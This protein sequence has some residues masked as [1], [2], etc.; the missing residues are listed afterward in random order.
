MSNLALFS[1]L[2]FIVITIAVSFW[3]KLGLEKDLAV[4][5]A[6]SA[7]QLFLIGY[8]LQYIFRAEQP[9]LILLMVMMMVSVASWN[10]AQRGKGLKGI[11]WR[12]AITIAFT[13][14]VTISLLLGFKIIEPASQSIIP[15]C[16]MVAGNSMIASSLFLAQM[17]RE[18]EASR[19]EIETLLSLG[20][21]NRQSIQDVIARAVK[22]SMIPNIDNMK[23]VGLVM[24][25]GVMTGM[26]VAGANPLEAVRY[27]ILIMFLFATSPAITSMLLS[28]LTYQLWFTK[29][30]MLKEK[31]EL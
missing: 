18:V 3:Q 11:W 21:T 1:T 17:K 13:E 24:L 16:G 30:S 9:F 29:N 5:T 14:L 12:A 7:V 26:I 4:N 2:V 6:R 10:V 28:L 23:T 31:R 27:Q 25:P 15:M 22:A 19:A 8:V 20:A